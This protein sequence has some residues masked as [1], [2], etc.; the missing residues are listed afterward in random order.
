MAYTPDSP[1]P[2]HP[3]HLECPRCGTHTVVMYGETKYV[4]LNCNWQRDLNHIQWNDF[5]IVLAAIVTTLIL[6][7]FMLPGQP[8]PE[9]APLL[10]DEEQPN[11]L[12]NSPLG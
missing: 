1:H 9:Y 8:E 12:P 11:S 7:L 10:P 3:H 4:C 2:N 6:L 5:P